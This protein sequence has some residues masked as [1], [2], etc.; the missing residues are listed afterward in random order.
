MHS[1]LTVV[2]FLRESNARYR[3]RLISSD[4][5]RFV[6]CESIDALASSIGEADVILGSISFPPR[7]LPQAE[8]VKWVQV[9]GA[10]VDA[11]LAG[12]PLPE[13][14]ILTRADLSFGDQIGEY[15]IGHLLAFTQR[16]RD[17]FTLQA[18]C[19]WRPLAVEF[20]RGRTMGVAGTGSIGRAVGSAALAMGMRT[21]GLARTP[22]TI[23][24]FETIYG[25]NE[26]D[27][28]LRALDVLVICLPLTPETRGLF[29]R[30]QLAL[31]KASSIVVNVAR[32]AIV[33]E[34]A[35]IEALQNHRIRGAILDAFE[36]EPLPV[37]SPLW[38]L[39]NV[40][41]TSHHA[42]LNIPDEVIDFFLENLHRFRAGE[43]L[44]GTVD[45]NRGY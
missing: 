30:E 12:G 28:F 5:V 24:G 8:R 31:L 38:T 20:L 17:V 23:D 4:A 2:V 14:V 43:S 34:S 37:D 42:G 41:V 33:D 19:S 13:D 29:G 3:E 18:Q 9:T 21:I 36:R 1:P 32:G 40:T 27:A 10:G 45:R 11:F 35:L 44:R 22:Q 26:L 25:P 39:D 16:L 7:L 6:F 15:V